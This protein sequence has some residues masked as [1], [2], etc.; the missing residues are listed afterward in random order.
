MIIELNFEKTGGYGGLT[1]HLH[2]E[3][4]VGN[5]RM[6]MTF[7]R[8]KL[9]VFLRAYDLTGCPFSYVLTISQNLLQ[10]RVPESIAVVK[11]VFR[12]LATEI[13][14]RGRG[15]LTHHLHSEAPVGNRRMAMTFAR[16]KLIVFLRAYDLTGC[17][18]S[19]VLTISQ[20]LLQ[21]R[22]PESIAVVE[23]CIQ[24]LGYRNTN[25]RPWRPY[26][27]FAF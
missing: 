24:E 20:N 26:S 1:H 9:I 23:N 11:T 21:P 3:A 18:F 27:S 15:G 13:Q 16:L 8:L 7:A 4:P 22:V 6:A 17:P 5:R 19:Y 12:N 10:P 2:S 25:K 14:T